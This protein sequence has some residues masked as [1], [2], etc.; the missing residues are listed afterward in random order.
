[1]SHIL[2]SSA[3]TLNAPCLTLRL[4]VLGAWNRM[5]KDFISERATNY[6]GVSFLICKMEPLRLTPHCCCQQIE[7]LLVSAQEVI[8]VAI[9]FLPTPHPQPPCLHFQG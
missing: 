6:L 8:I 3:S 7:S 1:M 9:Q 2:N 5:K 4:W